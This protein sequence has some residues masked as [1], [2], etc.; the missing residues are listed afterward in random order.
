MT[1]KRKHLLGIEELSFDEINYILQIAESFKEILSRPIKKIPPLRGKTIINLFFEPSTRTRT[2]FELAAKRLSADVINISTSTSS[3]IKGESLKDT[4]KTI[5]AMNADIVIVRHS[6]SGAPYILSQTIKSSII[7][8]G[9]GSHEHPTQALLDLFTIKEKKKNIE[10]L[11]IAIV[12]DIRHSRV[13]RSNIW[14]FTKLGA[15]VTLVA[16]PTLIPPD[17]QRFGN[18]INVSYNLKDCI[19]D[20]DVL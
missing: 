14:A 18:N 19:K 9:D 16:P 20:I 4:G 3:V 13:A 10:N 11:N 5:E 12:G 2:S 7:N 6:S 15:K 17:I 8:A 1:F